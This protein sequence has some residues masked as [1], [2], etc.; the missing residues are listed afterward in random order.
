MMCTPVICI[1]YKHFLVKV[2]GAVCLCSLLELLPLHTSVGDKELKFHVSTHSGCWANRPREELVAPYASVRRHKWRRARTDS[3]AL[4]K[5]SRWASAPR[6]FPLQKHH[7]LRKRS[8]R[9]SV[10][11][12]KSLGSKLFK[13]D[14][15]N[16]L[17]LADNW[18]T[19]R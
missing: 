5:L 4:R 16:T 18:H 14:V 1:N 8:T 7:G 2:G 6:L 11:R 3:E 12:K 10:S 19:H 13:R 17:N 15:L 9:N